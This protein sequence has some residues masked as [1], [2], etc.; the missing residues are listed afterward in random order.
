MHVSVH[1]SEGSAAPAGREYDC[2]VNANFG[3]ASASSGDRQRQSEITRVGNNH[4]RR[5]LVESAWNYRHPP[6]VG[7]RLRRRR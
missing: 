5:V 2:E 4:V 6:R 1:A 7:V 3:T